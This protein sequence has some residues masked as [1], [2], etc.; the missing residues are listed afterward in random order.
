MMR[1]RS[2]TPWWA[3][4]VSCS[5]RCG[6][7]KSR[8]LGGTAVDV[9]Q[10]TENGTRGHRPGPDFRMFVRRVHRQRSVRALG[11]VVRH[12]LTQQALQVPLVDDNKVVETLGS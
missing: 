8:V 2:C 9:V 1:C 3:A 11:V 5:T 12:E 4:P 6:T 10:A 7:A